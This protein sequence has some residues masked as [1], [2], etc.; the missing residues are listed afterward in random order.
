[1]VST[2]LILSLV[3]LGL[4]YLQNLMLYTQVH[5]LLPELLVFC[6]ALRHPLLLA[7]SL[8][9]LIGLLQDSYALTPLG[10]HVLAALII[11]GAARAAQ[12]KF[13][14]QHP[15]PQILIAA[16]ALLLQNLT[17]RLI[18][19]LVGFRETFFSDLTPSQGMEI[20]AT[21]ALTPLFFSLLTGVEK[22]TNPRRKQSLLSN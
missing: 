19:M 6:A 15:L 17:I 13:L 14:L 21:A 22:R 5:L 1:M 7:F 12:R 10:L 8:A 11:V 18:L 2:I 16:G 4:F 9:L 20:L 3:A